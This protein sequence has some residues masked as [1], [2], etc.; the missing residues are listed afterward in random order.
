MKH[1]KIYNEFFKV[2]S[3]FEFTGINDLDSIEKVELDNIIK[4][5]E[6]NSKKYLDTESC[7]VFRGIKNIDL[8]NGISKL[9]T[10]K[11]RK[12]KDTNTQVSDMLDD[13][14]K[15]ELGYRLRSSGNFTSRSLDVA[16][17]YGI[18]RLFIPIGNYKYFWS[19][20]IEDLFT[21]L[22]ECGWYH[23]FINSDQS[24]KQSNSRLD[25]DEYVD[26]ITY[27]VEGNIN[28]IVSQYTDDKVKSSNYHEI[29]FICDEYFIIDIKYTRFIE[30]YIRNRNT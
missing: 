26:D 22:D 13:S 5:L 1:L 2:Y 23:D 7:L 10:L 21:Y 30:E 24:Y 20:E 28:D 25:Y 18:P 6:E 3:G 11:N 4:L 27:E 15:S 29:I 12:P 14:F 19:S 9:I 17:T 16:G 8:S